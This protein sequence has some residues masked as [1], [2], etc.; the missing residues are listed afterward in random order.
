MYHQE[1][2]K[3]VELK[4]V[5]VQLTIKNKLI[6]FI[7]YLSTRRKVITEGIKIKVDDLYVN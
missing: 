3:T 4:D 1:F 6:F 7:T 2:Y 5:S